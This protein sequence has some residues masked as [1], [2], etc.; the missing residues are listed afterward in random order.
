MT[1]VLVSAGEPSGDL[2]AAAVVRALRHRDP[3]IEVE[4]VGGDRLES[5]GAHMLAG[6]DRLSAMGTVEALGSARH[7]WQLLRRLGDRIARGAYDAVLV[8]DYPGFHLRLATRAASLAVPVVYYVAPQ[9]WAWGAWRA[10]RLRSAVR[11][12]AVILP[13]EEAFFRGHGIPAT[14]VGHP[15]LD[16]PPRPPRSAARSQL[17]IDDAAKVLAL[18]PGKRAVERQRMWP[19]FRRAADLL[20]A[21]HPGLECVVAAEEGALEGLEGAR[22]TTDPWLALAGADAALCKSGTSTLEAALQGTPMVIAYRAQAVSY[23]LARRLVRVPHV[24]LVNLVAGESVA[25]ELLQDAASPEAISGA[26]EPLLCDGSSDAALQRA[27]F[28]H[29]RTRLGTPGAG[30]RVAAL[31]LEAAA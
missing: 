3:A 6:I 18:F 14:F 13:F 21:S 17:G 22:W 25:P 1:R 27:A 20:R 10:E 24:G 30:E 11:Q 4:A 5:A 16:A 26:L 9:L 7:H 19:V 8:V 28:E 2:H 31:V 12:L 23:W 15:L 29:V